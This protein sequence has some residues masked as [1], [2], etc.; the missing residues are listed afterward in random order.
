M[1]D[2]IQKERGYNSP[3]KLDRGIRCMVTAKMKKE[4]GREYGREHAEESRCGI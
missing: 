2:P 1:I 3:R 4:E